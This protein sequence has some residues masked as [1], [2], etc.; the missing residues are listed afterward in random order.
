MVDIAFSTSLYSPFVP[1][2]VWLGLCLPSQRRHVLPL[3]QL[4]GATWLTPCLPALPSAS[5][6][7]IQ[8][9]HKLNFNHRHRQCPRR[10]QHQAFER[11]GSRWMAPLGFLGFVLD[12]TVWW[13]LCYSSYVI[14]YSNSNIF[15]HIAVTVQTNKAFLYDFSYSFCKENSFPIQDPIR[16]YFFL[17]FN[18][19]VLKVWFFNPFRIGFGIA[20]GK[21][22]HIIFKN[23]CSFQQQLLNDLSFLHWF[24]VLFHT[25]RDCYF[26][27]IYS[28]SCID[29]FHFC[30]SSYL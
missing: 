26:W 3:V 16:I 10:W 6:L 15:C 11:T 29:L 19:I 8:I 7:E 20:W 30:K 14:S 22:E 21:V 1:G 23:V 27:N 9:R 4:N 12:A 17:A 2:L 13:T 28:T 25:Y 24:M 5:Q 18:G